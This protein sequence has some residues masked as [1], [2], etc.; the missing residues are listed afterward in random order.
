GHNGAGKTTLL[1]V[2][3][4]VTTPSKGSIDLSGSVAALIDLLVAFIP[5]L[6]GR[7]NLF[8]LASMHGVGRRAMSGR[9]QR[10]IDFAELSDEL[11]D[12]PVK[13]Y[14]AG[15]MA[16][17][18]FATIT[19][20]DAA[21]LLIDEVLAVGDALFQRRCIRWLEQYKQ[22]GGTLVFVSH[23]LSLVRSMTQRVLW[24]HQGELIGDGTAA[25]VIPEYVKALELRDSESATFR[26]GK[27]AD[28][29]ILARG[30][31]RWG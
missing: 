20:L 25:S 22:G 9:V 14:S 28:K 13:R 8:Y 17:L 31:Y 30:L 24:L 29:L 10:A 15:M 19:V 2:L 7:E 12:T 21:I 23:N 6:T 5:D 3:A 11:L 27:G 16:R 18:G 26:P 4:G 1:K